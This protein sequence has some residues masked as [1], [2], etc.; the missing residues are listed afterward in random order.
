MPLKV[1]DRLFHAI[2]AIVLVALCLGV[3]YVV[4][5]MLAGESA[6]RWDHLAGL[7]ADTK[8]LAAVRAELPRVREQLQ[9]KKRRAEELRQRIPNDPCEAEFLRQLTE[10]ADKEGLEIR[11][12]R[13]GAL[14][15]RDCYRQLQVDLS[16]AGS[17]ASICRF[18]M[19][20]KGLPRIFTIEKLSIASRPA[21][22]AY[23]CS[24]SIAVYFGDRGQ[25]QTD[26]GKENH[27]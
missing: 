4:H 25:A 12:Y 10:L 17:Y 8:D 15:V 20:L 22:E 23:P 19:Q 5:T 24:L 3:Y 27:G 14:T 16:C 9:Q 11:D 21:G 26:G 18:L 13:P 2:G 7:E 1:L 6:A